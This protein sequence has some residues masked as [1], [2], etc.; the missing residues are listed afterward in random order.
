MAISIRSSM[1][2]PGS[3]RHLQASL[4][5][6]SCLSNNHRDRCRFLGNRSFLQ[7][8]IMKVESSSQKKMAVVVSSVEPRTPLPSDPSDTDW[9]PWLVWMLFSVAIPFWK[10]IKELD[11]VEGVVEMLA[12]EVKKVAG[13]VE[14]AAR[15]AGQD[16][17]R[18]LR[19]SK[20]RWILSLRKSR[21][22]MIPRIRRLLKKRQ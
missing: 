22:I 16:A 8:L 6:P 11:T 20:T 21:K 14:I 18:G 12:G 5:R 10:K 2:S 15:E 3:S 7:P 4:L 9:K 13:I 19:K 17:R 1:S